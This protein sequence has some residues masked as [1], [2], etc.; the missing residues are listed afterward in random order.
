MIKAV[1]CRQTITGG[2]RGKSCEQNS[3]WQS[4]RPGE[5]K[6]RAVLETRTPAL[7]KVKQPENP[8]KKLKQNSRGLTK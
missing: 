4:E 1:A 3:Q 8:I 5:D 7:R 2:G 6:I